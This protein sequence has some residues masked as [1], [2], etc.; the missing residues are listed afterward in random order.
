MITLT[1]YNEGVYNSEVYNRF[2]EGGNEISLI[3]DGEKQYLASAGAGTLGI[4]NEWSAGFW[5]KPLE[6]PE[7]RVLFAAHNRDGKN[8]IEV[9]MPSLAP[10]P[11][12]GTFE[13]RARNT[14]LRVRITDENGDIIQHLGWGDMFRNDVWSHV[15]ISWDGMDILAYRDGELVSSGTGLL[16]SSGTMVDSERKIYYGNTISG[17]LPTWSGNIGH[18]GIWSS[19]LAQ[20]EWDTVVSGGFFMDL[21][22]ASAGYTSSGTLVQYWKPGANESNIGENLAGGVELTKLSFVSTANRVGDTPDQ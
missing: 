19:V 5:A 3:L 13:A 9:S 22:T 7:F 10:E 4:A 6:G 15:G 1:A 16:V 8:S 17:T 20:P 12:K 14:E 21:T 11:T 18:A 2:L